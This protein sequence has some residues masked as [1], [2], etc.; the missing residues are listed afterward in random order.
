MCASRPG[1]KAFFWNETFTYLYYLESLRMLG[2]RG[3]GPGF[4][5]S[6]PWEAL[7]AQVL[8]AARVIL[9]PGSVVEQREIEWSEAVGLVVETLPYTLPYGYVVSVV[10]E[11]MLESPEN[12]AL[13]CLLRAAAST[14]G[15]NGMQRLER[16]ALALL[17]SSWLKL[18]PR[19]TG[20]RDGRFQDIDKDLLASA[21]DRI[22]R[23][24]APR[25][26]KVLEPILEALKHGEPPPLGAPG[27]DEDA[28]S[29]A[30]ELYVLA[31]ALEAL[32]G[33]PTYYPNP[34]PLTIGPNGNL[35]AYYQRPLDENKCHIPD[36]TLESREPEPKGCIIE[37]K[38]ATKDTLIDQRV[39]EGF[40]QASYY[41]NI[42]KS[43]GLNSYRGLVVIVAHTPGV[44]ESTLRR[45]PRCWQTSQLRSLILTSRPADQQET[46]L[47]LHWCLQLY[48]NNN[49]TN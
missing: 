46:K 19:T 17:G 24:A 34:I 2:Q 5:A 14:F 42:L 47:A 29:R 15:D 25:I 48:S 7:A 18:I 38:A 37:V 26:F 30:A 33:D 4:T 31:L 6:G 41:L 1:D 40:Y 3:F 21:H 22:R 28:F 49:A 20:C 32:N 36:I 9:Q 27:G 44:D 43:R 12:I 45:I 10:Y 23:G 16:E 13:A 35:K 11:R 39:R 8:A